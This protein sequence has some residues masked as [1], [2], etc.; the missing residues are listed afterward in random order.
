MYK[1][2]VICKDTMMGRRTGGRGKKTKRRGFGVVNTH[3]HKHTVY[4]VAAARKK[5]IQWDDVTIN[6]RS[7][8]VRPPPSMC[9]SPPLV[10][11]GHVII[12]TAFYTRRAN[13]EGTVPQC[14]ESWLSGHDDSD[15]ESWWRCV[16]FGLV[17]RR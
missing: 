14:N 13:E 12:V 3:T 16:V 6:V 17:M 15:A 11:A 4:T 1:V 9:V 2:C 7:I 5:N 8:A 10:R